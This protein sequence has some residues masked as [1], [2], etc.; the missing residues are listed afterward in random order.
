MRQSHLGSLGFIGAKLCSR[1]GAGLVQ[2]LRSPQ[3]PRVSASITLK[4]HV[5]YLH[6]A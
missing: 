5:A 2:V 1:S 3:P 6:P 4:A